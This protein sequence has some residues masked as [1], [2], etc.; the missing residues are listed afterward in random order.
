M[1]FEDNSAVQA[2]EEV[3][4][5]RGAARAIS[6]RTH[7]FAKG[8]GKSEREPSCSRSST[9]LYLGEIFPGSEASRRVSPLV[10]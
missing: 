5:S 2:G 3:D 9:L 6:V 8:A 1:R 10:S 7:I 4:R